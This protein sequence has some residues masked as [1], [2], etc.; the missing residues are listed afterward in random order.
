MLRDAQPVVEV[1]SL[2]DCNTCTSVCVEKVRQLLFARVSWVSW[3]SD[4][5]LT[6][7]FVALSVTF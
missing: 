1:V 4:V 3:G 5:N 6:I 7:F 2:V